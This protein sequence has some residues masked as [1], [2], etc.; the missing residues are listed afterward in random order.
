[1]RPAPSEERRGVPARDLLFRNRRR[2]ARHPM[3]TAA[4]NLNFSA[5]STGFIDTIFS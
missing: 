3:L 4:Q 2:R 5:E 1:M